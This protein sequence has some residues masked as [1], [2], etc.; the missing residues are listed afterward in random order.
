MKYVIIVGP[1]EYMIKDSFDQHVNQIV[2]IAYMDFFL[3][4]LVFWLNTSL[5]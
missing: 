4:Y 5:L 1:H 3:V 2:W